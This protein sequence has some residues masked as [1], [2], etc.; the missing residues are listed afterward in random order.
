MKSEKRAQ[1]FNTDDASLPRSGW[2]F[3]LLLRFVVGGRPK[4]RASKTREKTGP[5]LRQLKPET[6]HER[7]LAPRVRGPSREPYQT[8]SMVYF[9]LGLLRT[10]L[11]SKG[12]L[13]AKVTNFFLKRKRI[14]FLSNSFVALEPKM[15]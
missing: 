12:I 1:K 3:R 5:F 8:V 14:S 9:I 7:A 4:T 13:F 6:A 10:D 2:C 11:W 15:L